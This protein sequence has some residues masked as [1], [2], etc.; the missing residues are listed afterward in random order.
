MKIEKIFN[1]LRTEFKKYEIGLLENKKQIAPDFNA[2]E[3]LYALELPLSKMIGEFLNPKGSHEQ[4]QIF[5]NLFIDKFLKN[6]LRLKKSKNISLKLEHV[7]ENGRIDILI[8]FDNKFGIAIENKPYADDQNRQIIRY[9]DYL[10]SVYGNN[11][12]S[13]IYLSADG[14]EPTEKSLTKNEREQLGKQ[15]VIISYPQL[16]TWYLDCAEI[17]KKTNSERLTVIINEFAEYINR[18]FCGTNSLKDNM[19]GETI[20]K[21]IIDAYELNLLWNKNKFDYENLWKKSINKLINKELPKLVFEK[22]ILDK[23]IDDNWKY[24]EGKFDIDKMH[25]EGFKIKKKNWKYFEYG[26]ISD[27]FKT[28]KGTR[29]FFPVIIS[30]IAVDNQNFNIEICQKTETEL[31]TIPLRKPPAIWYSN[32]PDKKFKTWDY[33]QWKEIK[34]NGKTVEYVANFLGKLIIASIA[35][36]ENA[37]NSEQKSNIYTKNEFK[38]FVSKFQWIFAKTYAD[39]APHEYITL[40]KVGQQYKD[41]FVKIAQFIRDEGF[42][43]MYYTREG[44]YYKLDENYYWTM[45][46]N[47]NDTNLINRAKLSDYELIDNSWHWKGRNKK[48]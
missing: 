7:T 23:I 36:I 11:N 24:V 8:D 2:F 31:E 12:F 9:C 15:F 33:E 3:I 16:R 18:I 45:D 22:L 38:N 41:E 14:S 1:E 40:D 26:V 29:N 10:S 37:E 5:L 34:P 6:N 13:M 39:K 28:E 42:K 46:D 35:D 48:V 43:A 25:L 30:K 27:R 44:Y 19:I 20:K 4:G 17:T 47:I 21:N 32:F